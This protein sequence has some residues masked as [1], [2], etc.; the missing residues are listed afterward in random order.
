MTGHEDREREV[1]TASRYA[2]KDLERDARR[3]IPKGAKYRGYTIVVRSNG[4]V[5]LNAHYELMDELTFVS[6]AL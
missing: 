4:R 1:V 2:D 3:L 6:V 5:S